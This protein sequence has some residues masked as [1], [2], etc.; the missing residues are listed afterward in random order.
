MP[1]NRAPA[2][3]FEEDFENTIDGDN[4]L[5]SEYR[6]AAGETYTADPYWIDRVQCN[7]FIV[8]ETSSASAGDCTGHP[9]TSA[10]A[11]ERLRGLAH[12]LGLVDAAPA[13]DRNGVAASYTQSVGTVPTNA[14]QFRSSPL[15]LPNADG[16]FLTF[17][18]DAGATNCFAAQPKLRFSFMADEG[19]EVPVGAAAINP[20]DDERSRQYSVGGARYDAG[21]FVADAAVLFEGSSLQV[22]MR[23]E[24]GSGS[25]NDGAY[26]NIRV[27]DATPRLEKSFSPDRVRAGESS[28]LTLTV[29]NTAERAEK[30]GWAFTDT[31]PDGLV[32][33]APG[34]VGGTCEAKVSAVAGSGEIAVREG[35]LPA[36]SRS[37]TISVEV[38]STEPAASDG[39]RTFRNCAANISVARGID[40]PACAAVT[41]FRTPKLQVVKVSD[42]ASSNAPGDVVT[43]EVT[44]TNVGD[45]DYA[46]DNPAAVTDDMTDLLDDAT[47]RND[48]ISD[49]G[50]LAYSPPTLHW[51]G[52]LAVGESVKLRYSVALGARGDQQASNIVYVDGK[53]DTPPDCSHA[54]QEQGICDIVD[55]PI[56]LTRA[57]AI[58]K[59]S[60]ADRS[61]QEGATV[62]YTVR[63]TNTGTADFTEH[64]PARVVDDMAGTLDDATYN[65]DA[66]ASAG[67]VAFSSPRLTWS[68]A[69]Q[70]GASV[71]LRYSVTVKAGGDRTARNIAFVAG[72]GDVTPACADD[73]R[74]CDV[75]E[76][77][78]DV[79]PVSS[80]ATTGGQAAFASVGLGGTAL[81]LG[82][83]LLA[84]RRAHRRPTR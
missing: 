25:G 24:T 79:A 84:R 51:T 53:T 77:A 3:V 11:F 34:R 29:S 45:G 40:P 59:T 32:I 30:R 44:A 37:C 58:E 63:L 81:L 55:Y 67:S 54:D 14:M 36:G 2:I 41:F 46:E 70:A 62:E 64:D 19:T 42:A 78:L 71:E 39:E 60:T 1:E 13:P 6:G 52:P 28:T 43:Y 20:C 66:T 57:L 82:A 21:S 72:L 7:G 5:L 17:S 83:A 61:A 49:R 75:V 31:L 47:Y 12:V 74:T 23:N 50:T 16:R 27:L 80:L 73:A 10:T 38:T 9:G 15:T 56:T 65:A 4:I 69:L 18:V 48:A 33:A 22:V 76:Y 68:G 26:D 35:V 8:D